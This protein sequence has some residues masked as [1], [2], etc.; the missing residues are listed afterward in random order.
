MESFARLWIALIN[1][2]AGWPVATRGWLAN[3]LGDLL[4]LLVLPRRRVTLVNLRACFPQMPEAERRAAA[5][6]F[7]ASGSSNSA[8]LPSTMLP[9]SAKA[10]A[11][12]TMR[13]LF[14]QDF[15][16]FL[17]LEVTYRRT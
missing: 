6:R 8:A 13:C 2:T 11:T 17:P 14:R 15:I 3:V 9:S 1:A 5:A 12:P 4:W 7:K 10:R 16:R